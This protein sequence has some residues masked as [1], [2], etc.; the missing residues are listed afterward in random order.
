[1]SQPDTDRPL[2]T[3]AVAGSVRAV[4][5][6]TPGEE[7]PVRPPR[8]RLAAVPTGSVVA[9]SLIFPLDAGEESH[10]RESALPAGQRRRAMRLR[11]HRPLTTSRTQRREWPSSRRAWT[12]CA[13]STTSSGRPTRCFVDHC[14]GF[15]RASRLAVRNG[16]LE[17]PE[18]AHHASRPTTRQQPDVDGRQDPADPRHHR[19]ATT[20]DADADVTGNKLGR[21]W[22][23]L[24]RFTGS[25]GTTGRPGAGHDHEVELWDLARCAR[26]APLSRLSAEALVGVEDLDSRVVPSSSSSRSVL[27]L[28]AP[29]PRGGEHTTAIRDWNQTCDVVFS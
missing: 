7:G 10:G 28:V 17:V 2:V 23:G 9:V 12:S 6:T 16:V 3:V 18:V 26:P 8:V 20:A 14:P 15:E 25:T 19:G 1:M 13:P 11:A 22:G 5:S 24:Q 4:T 29:Q 27:D 21:D